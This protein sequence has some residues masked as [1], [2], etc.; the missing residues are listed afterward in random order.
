[1]ELGSLLLSECQSVFNQLL[2]FLSV[3][4]DQVFTG[5]SILAHN[6]PT[7]KG[8]KEIKANE[9]M[10]SRS[11]SLSLKLQTFYPSARD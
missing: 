4:K 10:V 1:M 9:E 2:L 5:L 6:D 8:P 3:N 7:Y 11:L